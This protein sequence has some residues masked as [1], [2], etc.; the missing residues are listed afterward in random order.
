MKHDPEPAT[1][2]RDQ[3]DAEPVSALTASV[4]ELLHALN[5]EASELTQLSASTEEEESTHGTD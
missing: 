2:S 5:S 4:F 3:L 1:A